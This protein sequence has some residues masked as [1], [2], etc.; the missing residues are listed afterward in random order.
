M[1][2][3]VKKP[4]SLFSYW[5]YVVNDFLEMSC[6]L[7]ETERSPLIRELRSGGPFQ[8]AVDVHPTFSIDGKLVSVVKHTPVHE[9]WLYNA[10]DGKVRKFEVKE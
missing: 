5:E 3:P 7:K 1:K 9:I 4:R 10:D 8:E 2:A 6:F